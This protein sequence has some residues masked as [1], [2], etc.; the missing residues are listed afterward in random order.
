M[1]QVSSIRDSLGERTPTVLIRSAKELSPEQQRSLIRTFSALADRNVNM[2]I[3]IDPDLISG[4]YIRMG[5]LVVANNIKVEL[6]QLKTEITDSL[7][8]SISDGD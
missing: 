6:D 5:D 1:H 2:E 8:E 4:I 7:V 3:D